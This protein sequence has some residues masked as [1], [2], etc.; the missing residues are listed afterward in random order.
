MQRLT[1]SLIA[2]T[3]ATS[4]TAASASDVNSAA[5]FGANAFSKFVNIYP[6]TREDE[7]KWLIQRLEAVCSSKLRSD[8]RR[9]DRAWRIIADGYA[10][11]QARR[12]AEA[13]SATD[14]LKD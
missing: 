12:A 3:L 5:A 8:Q 10:K 4:A 11:L 2:L 7:R 13:T 6:R 9:C 14:A 1:T